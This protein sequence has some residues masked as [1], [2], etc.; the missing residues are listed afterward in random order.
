MSSIGVFVDATLDQV[1]RIVGEV[2][3]G[4]VQ[5]QGAEP[6]EMIEALRRA[7]PSLFIS[8]VIR[9]LDARSLA[10]TNPLLRVLGALG[11]FQIAE[12]HVS[13]PEKCNMLPTQ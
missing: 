1:L 12:I 5:L 8:K 6:P 4:G 9:M 11:R 3:L 10:A 7:R 13:S 2:G